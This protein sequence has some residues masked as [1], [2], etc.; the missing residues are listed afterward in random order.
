MFCFFH[1][2]HS[3]L[4]PLLGQRDG[5]EAERHGRALQLSHLQ[6]LQGGGLPRRRG[7]L[8]AGR[9]AGLWAGR[10]RQSGSG[11]RQLHRIRPVSALLV[12]FQLCEYLLE[13]IR[14]QLPPTSLYTVR[15][16]RFDYRIFCISNYTI[17]FNIIFLHLSAL[18]VSFSWPADK[19]IVKYFI[20]SYKRA[21]VMWKSEPVFVNLWRSPGIDSLPGGLVRQPYL[22]YRPSRLQTPAKSIPRNRFLGSIYI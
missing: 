16:G 12:F 3:P 10:L 7:E 5:V 8:C 11:R 2:S 9:R 13:Y 21:L 1:W 19:I 15:R 17:T 6:D 14:A 18:L 4:S 22:S 20:F